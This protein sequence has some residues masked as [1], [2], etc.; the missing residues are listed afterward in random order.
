MT[1]VVGIAI[2][3][4]AVTAQVHDARSGRRVREYSAPVAA[5]VGGVEGELD[6]DAVVAAA[7]ECLEGIDGGSSR[8]ASVSS[9]LHGLVLADGTGRAVRPAMFA[10]DRRSVADAGWCRKKFA[11]E[12]WA[13]QV[14]LVPTANHP[15]TKFS[16]VHRSEAEVWGRA[17]HFVAP[18]D[19]V[20][21]ALVGDQGRLLTDPA[22]ASGTGYWS[23]AVAAYVPEVLSLIDDGRDWSVA[24]PAVVPAGTEL[25]S[26]GNLTLTVGTS[27]IAAMS[28]AI[29]MEPGDVM[30]VLEEPVRIVVLA[31]DGA[32]VSPVAGDDG[33]WV[34]P[35][36]DAQGRSVASVAPEGRGD[37][38]TPD[39]VRSVLE[40]FERSGTTTG[41]GITVVG[42]HSDV[43]VV[44]PWLA[45]AMGRRVLRCG[46]QDA[47][48][49]GA[50]RCA[51]VALGGAW[52]Q[53]Q[54]PASQR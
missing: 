21:A 15:V 8:T 36:V 44:A 45:K 25:G 48:A 12:W 13:D 33:L 35:L 37:V 26:R 23:S 19:Y 27:R 53:W 4:H 51:A 3:E 14:G 39:L 6:I 24:L 20:A 17:E 22:A 43:S 7:I 28:A 47:A 32:T 16:W 41:G 42:D 54:V 2:S 5:P 1:H 31:P 52:P 46:A 38:V 30:I 40:L 10:S 29:G 9:P 18:H 49:M 34:E 11:P 50:A